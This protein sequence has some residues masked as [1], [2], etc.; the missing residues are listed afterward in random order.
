MKYFV[1]IINVS[2]FYFPNFIFKIQFWICKV[3]VVHLYF[4][5]GSEAGARVF[6]GLSIS[7][8][9]VVETDKNVHN[10]KY[11]KQNLF[12]FLSIP[13]AAKEK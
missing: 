11:V 10:L 8:N 1:R 9:S 4:K 5:F 12:F 7:D 6:L 13:D 3:H 2:C